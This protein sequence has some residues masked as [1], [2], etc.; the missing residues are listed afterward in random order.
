MRKVISKNVYALYPGGQLLQDDY[1]KR[2]REK[3]FGQD[4]YK[5]KEDTSPFKDK[6]TVLSPTGFGANER[7]NN[8]GAG[9]GLDRE[10]SHM[11]ARGVGSGYN[12]GEAANDET[13]PGGATVTPNPYYGQDVFNDLFLDLSLK[14][15]SGRDQVRTHLNNLLRG[16]QVVLPHQRYTVD[17]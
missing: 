9:M 11:K 12:D 16:S 8:P 4:A 5:T 15:D 2:I 6:K 13:G 7:Q 10:K 3:A 14:N 17:G 1:F